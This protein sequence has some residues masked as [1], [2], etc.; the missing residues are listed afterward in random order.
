MHHRFRGL[1]EEFRYYLEARGGWP[2]EEYV[3]GWLSSHQRGVQRGTLSLLRRGELV[4][5]KCVLGLI[6]LLVAESE[7][8]PA[9]PLRHTWLVVLDFLRE[10]GVHTLTQVSVGSL[11]GHIATSPTTQREG[12]V[13]GD[14]LRR[15]IEAIGDVVS[16]TTSVSRFV[17]GCSTLSELRTVVEWAFACVGQSM[18]PR[19]T[20]TD[21]RAAALLGEKHIRMSQE[22]YVEA[23]IRWHTYNPW[24]IVF[25]CDKNVRLGISIVLPISDAAFD[26]VLEGRRATHDLL[27][28]DF[29]RPCRN[30]VLEACAECPTQL[31]PAG[32]NPTRSLLVS[33]AV[34]SGALSKARA[35]RSGTVVRF[36]SFGGTTRN[37]DRLVDSGF[38]TT[39]R[40]MARNGFELFTRSVT[41][42]PFSTQ[43]V[44][45]AFL[46]YFSAAGSHPPPVASAID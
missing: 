25:A 19:G 43:L 11:L 1:T 3:Y 14:Y 5:E 30:L 20:N 2:P 38:R 13:I 16:P 4:A 18:G 37:R 33:L 26:D 35:L 46:N 27:P 22:Q 10:R 21:I 28:S 31:Q 44:S 12:T 15:G 17:Q 40:L 7:P 6:D 32:T 41:L 23:V 34:Q 29:V 36:L 42:G 8:G 9:H 39:G 24:T 45:G